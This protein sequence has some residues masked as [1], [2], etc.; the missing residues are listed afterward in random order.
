MYTIAKYVLF[1]TLW[2]WTAGAHAQSPATPAEQGGYYT[3]SQDEL[4]ELIIAY[5]SQEKKL[6]GD[7]QIEWVGRLN[8]PVY[9]NIQPFEPEITGF[10]MQEQ[11]QRFV[12][13][14]AFVGPE[15]AETGQSPTYSTMRL[16]GRY[17]S[18]MEVPV[19]NRRM[20]KGEVI[21]QADVD[22]VK[23]PSDKLRDDAI[24][25]IEGLVGH[26]P[27]R[28]IMPG[29]PIR[30]DEV[31]TPRLIQKG[32]TVSMEYE[33][34]SIILTASGVALGEGG[35]GDSIQVRNTQS[36]KVVQGIVMSDGK[37]KVIP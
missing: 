23:L 3:V 32:Q 1:L 20:E 14:I 24:L 5:L 29:R 36:N 35:A 22:L 18:V 11:A 7:V 31:V 26:S 28:A 17:F 21:E 4:K 37:V 10:Q 6:G 19:V 8:D 25:A 30:E 34:G 9:Q 2:V 27:R 13:S 33:N 15:M 12:A 16:I